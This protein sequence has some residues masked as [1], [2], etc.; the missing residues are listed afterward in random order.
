M[1]GSITNGGSNSGCSLFFWSA[2]TCQRFGRLRP[3]AACN[4]CARRSRTSCKA[5]MMPLD[6]SQEETGIPHMTG[7]HAVLWTATA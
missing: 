1:R 4:G 3:V 2:L 7:T 5:G 6:H